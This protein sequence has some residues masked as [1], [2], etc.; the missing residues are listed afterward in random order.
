MPAVTS[1]P[2]PPLKELAEQGWVDLPVACPVLE[3][4][5]HVDHNFYAFRN[6]QTGK[7]ER[8]YADACSTAIKDSR[9]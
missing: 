6:K 3:Q 4:L 1:S 8:D 9:S 2:P 5:E 7:G